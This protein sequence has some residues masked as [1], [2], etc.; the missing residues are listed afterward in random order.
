M[1][2]LILGAGSVGGYLGA[3]LVDAGGDV[4][5]LVRPERAKQLASDGLRIF[6]PLGDL[7]ITPRVMLAGEL[8]GVYDVV[9]L[10]CKAYDIIPAVDT[11]A[12][13][14]G[15]D[16]IVVPLL[17]GVA[18][19]EALDARFGIRRVWGGTAHI[20]LTMTANGAIRHLNDYHRFIAGPRGGGLRMPAF[21][22]LLAKANVEAHIA[23][24]IEQ[25]MWSKFVF[26]TTLAG[27]TCT[28][29]ASIG[30]ILNTIAG[31]SFIMD[32]WTECRSVAANQGHAP[33]APLSVRYLAQLTERGSTMKSSMLRDIQEGNTTEADH[34]LGDMLCRAQMVDLDT[35]LLRLAY[36]HLQA[37]ELQRRSAGAATR[38][39]LASDDGRVK[40]G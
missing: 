32:L 21:E 29:R 1:R 26:L 23:E 19:L 9:V 17:N 36:A 34:I 2:I 4:T 11:V 10:T 6:S 24:D 15:A 3:R 13:A 33:P 30:D 22:A 20:S 40:S 35:P 38:P 31:E 25:E 8:E 12:P 39:K 27:A 18:H 14:V 16:T 37:Y 7:R 28:M 5:F